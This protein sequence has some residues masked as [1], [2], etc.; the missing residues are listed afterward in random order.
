MRR[1]G[2]VVPFSESDECVCAAFG[3]GDRVRALRT[4]LKDFTDTVAYQDSIDTEDNQDV[5]WISASPTKRSSNSSVYVDC[6]TR[7][8]WLYATTAL[9]TSKTACDQDEECVL[10]KS[11]ADRVTPTSIS[12]DPAF[13]G[14]TQE[15]QMGISAANECLT[16]VRRSRRFF[17]RFTSQSLATTHKTCV[18]CTTNGI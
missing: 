7:Q 1:K 11:S 18:S 16:G 9:R 6:A 8:T 13:T 5:L 14:Q 3:E 4:R 17:R 15:E 12:Q 2:N 10:C